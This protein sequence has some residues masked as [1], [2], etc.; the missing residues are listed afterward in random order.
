MCKHIFHLEN[1]LK[2][3]LSKAMG[4]FKTQTERGKFQ[5]KDTS[6]EFGHTHFLRNNSFGCPSVV[7]ML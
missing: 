7:N 3:L 4:S 1:E 5:A 6:K 2:Y